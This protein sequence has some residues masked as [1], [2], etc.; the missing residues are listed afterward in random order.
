V[1]K[2]VV[3]DTN[4]L[5]IAEGLSDF[6]RPCEARCG[7]LLRAIQRDQIV[8]LDGGREILTEYKKKLSERKG[9]PGLGYEFWK[10][11]INTKGN[12]A[13]YETVE[14]TFHPDK[15]Y[16]QFPDHHGLKEFDRS[17]RKFVAVAAAHPRKPEIIQAGDSKWWG[18]RYALGECGVRLN[19]PCETELR[20]KWEAKIGRNE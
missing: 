16:D 18:W 3:I 15:G 9:Q 4:V 5:L 14:L 1:S 17:D 20:A 6:S 8:V 2:A 19:L 7:K 12:R 10:W 13:H 11:L